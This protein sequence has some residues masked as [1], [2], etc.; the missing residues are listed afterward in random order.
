LPFYFFFAVL[1]LQ[2]GRFSSFK[3][4]YLKISKPE[5]SISSKNEFIRSV[6]P[7]PGCPKIMSVDGQSVSILV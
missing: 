2:M 1:V 4:R 5:T 6:L 3:N 7:N